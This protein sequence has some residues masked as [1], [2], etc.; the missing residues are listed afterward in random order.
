MNLK[1]L[2]V[3]KNY[4]PKNLKTIPCLFHANHKTSSLGWDLVPGLIGVEVLFKSQMKISLSAAPVAR[5]F[6]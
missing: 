2:N 4:T 6:V 5:I 1:I 3:S